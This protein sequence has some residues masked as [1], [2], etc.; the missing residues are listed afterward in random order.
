MQLQTGVTNRFDLFRSHQCSIALKKTIFN[1]HGL[2][3]LLIVHIVIE[4]TSYEY[5]CIWQ[6][7]QV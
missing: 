1:C 5:Y 4:L 7:V 2:M 3:G 6:I